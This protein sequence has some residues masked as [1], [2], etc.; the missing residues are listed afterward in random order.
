MC[1]NNSICHVEVLQGVAY[2]PLFLLGLL[3]N[4]AALYAFIVRRDSWTDTHVYMLNLAVAD[5]ALVIF[6]PFR[7]YDAFYCL[8]RT[9]LCTLLISTH[10]INMYASILTSTAIS[11]HRY[12][13]VRFPMQTRAWRRKKEVAGAICV[14]IWVVVVAICAVYRETYF[15]E[16][17]STCYERD[18]TVQLPVG[19]LM[20]LLIIGFL[21]PL[22][23]IV[24]CSRQIICTLFKDNDDS[25]EKKNIGGMVTANMI[26]FIVC[27]TPIHVALILRYFVKSPVDLHCETTFKHSF[28]LVSEW[29]ATTNCCLDSI[30][31]YF[32]LRH[33]YL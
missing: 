25:T 19:F 21:A 30:S 26:V 17:L 7:I 3:L 14:A 5:F 29:I 13:A 1:I 12:L 18:R 2:I 31:Y 20:N 11:V 22:L 6:L 9:F 23:I 8:S 10:Y 32:L 15:P 16:R 27:Y 33:F 28:L 24:F 4:A